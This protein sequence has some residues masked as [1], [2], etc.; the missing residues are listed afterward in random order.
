MNG[1]LAFSTQN[2]DI[3]ENNG[4]GKQKI[5]DAR[6]SR[7]EYLHHDT[8]PF[9]LKSSGETKSNPLNN[10]TCGLIQK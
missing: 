7:L 4:V 3:G 1:R 9:L 5:C 10:M 8:C 6:M 2:L